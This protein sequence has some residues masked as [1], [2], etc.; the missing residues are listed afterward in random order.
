[1]D[2]A[3]FAALVG[4]LVMYYQLVAHGCT[5]IGGPMQ[6]VKPPS[7]EP[8]PGPSALEGRCSTGRLD[9]SKA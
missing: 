1:M 6:P 5:T 3:F 2:G 8:S 9:C 4:F 7:Q